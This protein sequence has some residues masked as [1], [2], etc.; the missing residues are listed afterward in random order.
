LGGGQYDTLALTTGRRDPAGWRA[1]PSVHAA[2]R[3]IVSIGLFD[4]FAATSLR[5]MAKQPD[6]R[7]ILCFFEAIVSVFV[8]IL[9]LTAQSNPWPVGC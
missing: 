6:A 5:V 8:A 9:S 4:G 1:A 3:V 2:C 7:G